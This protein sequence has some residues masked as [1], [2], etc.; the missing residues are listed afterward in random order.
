MYMQNREKQ[1]KEVKGYFMNV[2]NEKK[3]TTILFLVSVPYSKVTVS[4]KLKNFDLF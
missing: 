1:S 2:N 4:Q 3:D